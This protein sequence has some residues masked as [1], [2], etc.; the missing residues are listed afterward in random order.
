MP[1][2]A[3]REPARWILDRLDYPVVGVSG[4]TQA[5]AE[6]A[7]PLMVMRLH[8]R[9]RPEQRGDSRPF[10][11]RHVVLAELARAVLVLLVADDLREVL[12]EVAAER[13]VEHLRAAA[14][15]EHGQVTGE[16]RRQQ[17]QL[18]S[19]ARGDDSDGLWMSLLPVQLGIQIGAAREDQP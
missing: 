19:I 4:G 9:V 7:D 10:L 6:P 12:D 2:D 1:Q 11:E 5:L 15:R 16:R 13:N 14:D 18:G 17:R 3:E 8:R